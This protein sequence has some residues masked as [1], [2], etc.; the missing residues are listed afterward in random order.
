M[1]PALAAHA[2]KNHGPKFAN[3][4]VPNIMFVEKDNVSSSVDNRSSSLALR[5]LLCTGMAHDA[6]NHRTSW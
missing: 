5:F 1:L 6:T 2:C 3:E 4:C